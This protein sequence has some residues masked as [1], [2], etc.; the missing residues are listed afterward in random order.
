MSDE[1]TNERVD[2]IDV[3]HVLER[4]VA[5][6]EKGLRNLRFVYQT[7]GLDVAISIGPREREV[8]ELPCATERQRTENTGE[9][10][11]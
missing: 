4:W 2:L 3:L 8:T 7:G 5:T 11:Q 10:G 6:R 9:N 1:K